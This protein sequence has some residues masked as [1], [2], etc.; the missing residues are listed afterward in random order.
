MYNKIVANIKDKKKRYSEVSKSIAAA[1]ADL[2]QRKAER[3]R[4]IMNSYF[5][6]MRDLAKQQNI[7]VVKLPAHTL[8][9]AV[10]KPAKMYTTLLLSKQLMLHHEEILPTILYS[11]KN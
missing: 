10:M 3:R 8:N 7:L 9:Q 11:V 4:E 6:T 5:Q 1:I 2:R